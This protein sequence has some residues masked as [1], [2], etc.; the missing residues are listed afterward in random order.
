MGTLCHDAV[1]RLATTSALSFRPL[2]GIAEEIDV[3]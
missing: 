1:Y 3:G 2:A